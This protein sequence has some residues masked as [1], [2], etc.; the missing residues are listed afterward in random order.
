MS[1]GDEQ[2]RRIDLRIAIAG[3]FI[4]VLTFL[5][6]V[7][8][9]EISRKLFNRATGHSAANFEVRCD[10]S[11]LLVR[12]D[13]AI[14]PKSIKIEVTNH[15]P[16][17]IK[18]IR[19]DISTY[20]SWAGGKAEDQQITPE[21]FEHEFNGVLKPGERDEIQILPAVVAYV[22]T[23]NPPPGQETFWALCRVA[24]SVQIV[25][26]AYFISGPKIR[27]GDGDSTSTFV[28]FGMTWEASDKVKKSP[29]NF[30]V[31]R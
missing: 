26:D 31:S 17:P 22:K 6:T 27:T 13:T 19:F 21:R 8:G 9:T 2:K 29:L 25:G 15:G 5:A 7:Y 18:A 10:T 23:L 16:D 11:H 12:A 3:V 20:I 14:E 28:S 30:G 1:A 24:C 4:A